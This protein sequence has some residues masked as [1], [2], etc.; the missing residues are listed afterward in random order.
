M[1]RFFLQ[2][3]AL[4][5]VAAAIALLLALAA[6]SY[7]STQRST[8]SAQ[9]VVHTEEVL[10]RL[11]LLR[12]DITESKSASLGYTFTGDEGYLDSFQ[13]ALDR[14]S[15][16]LKTL[17]V[18]TANDLSQQRALSQVEPLIAEDSG[19]MREITNLR[20]TNATEAAVYL[21]RTKGEPLS[22]EIRRR[23]QEMTDEERR[24]FGDAFAREAADTQR[25]NILRRMVF[26]AALTLLLTALWFL[27]HS[28]THKRLEEQR[29]TFFQV[30]LDMLCFAGFDGY[31]QRLNPAWEKTLGF[32]PSELMSKP[33][34]EFVHPEDRESTLRQAAAVRSGSRAISFENRFVCKDGSYKWLMWNAVPVPEE[35]IIYAAA[36]DLTERKRTEA[37]LHELSLTDEMTKLRNRRGFLLLA[38]Q[39]LELV[40]GKRRDDYLWLIFADLDGLKTI[41][42]ELGH[43]AGS[44]A[45][46][47]AAEILTKSFRK[48]D[49]IARLGGDEFAILALDN[50]PDGGNTM[51]A[52]VQDT[53]HRFN[54][55]NSLPYRLS[56]SLGVVKVHAEQVASI[57]DLLNEA[58]QKMYEHKRSKKRDVAP[59]QSRTQT[60]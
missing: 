16:N 49:V 33:Q 31:F 54:V 60:P 38:E 48:A 22:D 6:I 8:G 23:S 13:K 45:I 7:Q 36:R 47:H 44:Q 46:V 29:E 24:L 14:S 30:S 25:A 26:A 57:K 37:L 18:L 1:R 35:K 2:H 5:F 15:A 20:R 39:E 43:D 42:D 17:R 40:R 21:A 51:C 12:A 59:D 58:D 41:N 52:R 53:L 55:E 34:I 19:L 9:S 11:N 50:E 3:L 27:I 28:L 4:A 32:T 10:S 56:L